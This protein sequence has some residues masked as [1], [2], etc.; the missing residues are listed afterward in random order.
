MCAAGERSYDIGDLLTF[1]FG[2]KLPDLPNHIRSAGLLL[3]ADKAFSR[4]APN[5]VMLHAY[6]R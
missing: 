5:T 2:E 4:P 3:F 1:G 6:D